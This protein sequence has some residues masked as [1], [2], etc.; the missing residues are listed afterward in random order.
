MSTIKVF[1]LHPAGSDPFSASE[2][3]MKELFDAELA[4]QGGNLTHYCCGRDCIGSFSISNR[5]VL[6]LLHKNIGELAI[7]SM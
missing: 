2:S 5:C 7:L 6:I 3:Y 4:L 1:D